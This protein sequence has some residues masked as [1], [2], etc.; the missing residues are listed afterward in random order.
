MTPAI[1][2]LNLGLC[3]AALTALCLSLNRHHAEVLQ[4]K[5][6]A[7]RVMLLRI[8]GWTGIGLSLPVAGVAEGW[9][10][11]PVQWLGTLTGAAVALVLLLS[12]Q[13]H[14]VGR[15]CGASVALVLAVSAL[16]HFA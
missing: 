7:R 6:S 15:A 1:L 9:N 12:Y 13:P 5:P 4:A 11:G 16:L 3:F 2:V 8:L 10:F 14:L